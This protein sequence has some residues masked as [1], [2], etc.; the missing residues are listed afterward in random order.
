ME[1]ATHLKD[2]VKYN[3]YGMPRNRFE[4][5]CRWVVFFIPYV[6]LKIVNQE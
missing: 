4:Q 2:A 3:K 6:S 1:T 5:L